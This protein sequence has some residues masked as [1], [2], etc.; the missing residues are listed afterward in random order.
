MLG[1]MRQ[2]LNNLSPN[3]PKN[4]FSLVEL[5]IVLVILG[6]LVGGVLTGQSL[7]RAAELRAISAEFSRYSAAAQSF[8]DKYFALPGDMSNA[9]QFWGAA[10]ATPATCRSTVGTGTQTCDGNGDGR[11]SEAGGGGTIPDED[12]RFWQH[13]ANAGLIEGNYTGV[14]TGTYIS[15]TL[16]SPQS[17]LRPA[18][19]F[20]YSWGTLSGAPL[21]DGNYGNSFAIGLPVTNTWVIGP[22][23][24]P[25]ETWN[26]DTKL[27]D[28][29]PGTGS[30]VIAVTNFASNNCTN[31]T[32]SSSQNA[33]YTLT[34][35]AAACAA[36][37][38]NA[39]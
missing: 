9:T 32:S 33:T 36:I 17:K 16:N 23:L 20:T 11:V 22:F 35:N 25:E 2:S 28:G 13:L 8:R 19:W 30:F 38:R 14:D 7:I 5:S 29:R 1:R 18:L 3:S 39:Y 31:S 37:F 4:G 27:D 34:H 12:Y 26:I 10:H 6:L 15:T 24:K 21:F